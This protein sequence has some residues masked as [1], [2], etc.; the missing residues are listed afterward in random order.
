[1][2]T[3]TQALSLLVPMFLAFASGCSTFKGKST[4]ANDLAAN[5]PTIVGART[6]PGTFELNRNLQPAGPTEI[7]AEVKDFTSSISEV[8]VRF[9]NVPMEVPMTHIGGSTWRAEL[10]PA[11]LK[12]L[13]VG[14]QTMEYQ[15]NVI[16]KNADGQTAVSHEPLQ[17]S[18]KSPDLA[19]PTG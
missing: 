10:T 5:G 9:V 7:L 17:V 1:M 18:V 2:K 15:V 3:R 4:S 14:G 13:A 6:N 16:A 19:Q 8:R 12:M 11:Q